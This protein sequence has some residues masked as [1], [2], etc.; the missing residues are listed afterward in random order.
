MGIFS[1]VGVKVKNIGNH[2]LEKNGQNKQI[3]L[4]MAN[5]SLFLGHKI[6]YLMI[7][8]RSKL[9]NSVFNKSLI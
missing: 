1:Q 8:P 3:G 7:I 5:L 6:P 4:I 2:N 9:P